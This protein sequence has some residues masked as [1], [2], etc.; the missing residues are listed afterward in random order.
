MRELVT[1]A[2]AVTVNAAMTA[3]PV[4]VHSITAAAAGQYSFGINKM[5]EIDFP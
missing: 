1:P 5:H 3:P 4:N 2:P